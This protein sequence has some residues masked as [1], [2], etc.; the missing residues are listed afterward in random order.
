MLPEII[1][2]KYIKTE[3]TIEI[4][5]IPNVWKINYSGHFS[6]QDLIGFMSS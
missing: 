4:Y 2:I 5:F 1:K 3:N 6:H